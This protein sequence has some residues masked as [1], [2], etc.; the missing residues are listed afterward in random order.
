MPDLHGVRDSLPG[1]LKPRAGLPGQEQVQGPRR[2]PA[3]IDNTFITV[4]ERTEF[5]MA[6]NSQGNSQRE[7]PILLIM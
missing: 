5:G 1:A 2:R 7:R 3:L 4:S 6:Q